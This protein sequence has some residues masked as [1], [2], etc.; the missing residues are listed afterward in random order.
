[1]IQQS[2]GFSSACPHTW[3][4]VYTQ[5][6]Q[7]VFSFCIW[8]VKHTGTCYIFV[9]SKRN[10]IERVICTHPYIYIHVYLFIF[11]GQIRY[12]KTV[13]LLGDFFCQFNSFIT[14]FFTTHTFLLDNFSSILYWLHS[15]EAFYCLF[16]LT[17]FYQE[18]LIFP[19][20]PINKYFLV[21]A[22]CLKQVS[23]LTKVLRSITTFLKLFLFYWRLD[24]I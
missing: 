17:W 6:L 8:Q 16:Q 13:F 12:T 11:Q 2:L 15:W 10:N 22:G 21:V 7:I 24:F 1:M 3:P 4:S 23:P 20:C 9:I 19:A 14:K 5:F 18:N